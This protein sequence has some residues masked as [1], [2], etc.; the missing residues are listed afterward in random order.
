MKIKH[1]LL[2]YVIAIHILFLA[3]SIPLINYSKFW[4]IAIEIVIII[5]IIISLRLYRLLTKPFEFSFFGSETLKNKDFSNKFVPTGNYEIDLLIEVYNKMIDQLR[6]ERIISEEK[7]F[8]LDKLIES[9]PVGIITL[10][11]DEKIS[12][13]NSAAYNFLKIK[14]ETLLGKTLP[15]TGN[16]FLLHLNQCELDQNFTFSI[17]GIKK[18][19]CYKSHFINKGFPRHF[20]IFEELTNEILEAEKNAYGKVI[21]MMSHEVNNTVGSINSLLDT[22]RIYKNVLPHGKQTEYEDVIKI[23]IERN[24]N[25]GI[26]MSNFANVIRLP[27]PVLTDFDLNILI[28]KVILL[29]HALKSEKQINIEASGIEDKFVLKIDPIQFEQALMNIIKNSVESIIDSGKVLIILSKIERKLTIRDDGQG[30]TEENSKKLFTPFFSTK[31]HGQGI[32]LTLVR[33][34]LLNHSFKFSLSTKPD[35]FTDFEIWFDK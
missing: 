30:I 29:M 27:K 20:I 1:K 33:D 3:L 16:D 13:L 9:S 2:I 11:F 15:N 35:G 25:L 26:F 10:D 18:Y 34:I 24:L 28:K 23:A 17:N 22:I 19:K 31:P 12:S 8:F 14:P 7:N 21:R 4:I 6:E 5:S 32:G